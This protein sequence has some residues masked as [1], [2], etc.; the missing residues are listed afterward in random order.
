MTTRTRERTGRAR[1]FSRLFYYYYYFVFGVVVFVFGRDVV[2]PHSDG[3]EASGI[4]RVAA[5]LIVVSDS[6]DA[7]VSLSFQIDNDDNNFITVIIIV[8][9]MYMYTR[10]EKRGFSSISLSLNP[11]Q[12]QR[13]SRRPAGRDCDNIIVTSRAT[14]ACSGV[15]RRI[16]P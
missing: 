6:Y 14:T 16:M 2:F 15:L 3:Y 13:R 1:R 11:R 8:L 9:L 5:D 12:I 7:F 4:T 10:G